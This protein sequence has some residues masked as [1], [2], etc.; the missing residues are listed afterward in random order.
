MRSGFHANDASFAGQLREEHSGWHFCSSWGERDLPLSHSVSS[1]AD[2]LCAAERGDEVSEVLQAPL[3]CHLYAS[4]IVSVS[5]LPS[6]ALRRLRKG[7]PIPPVKV[8]MDASQG[9]TKL[10][11]TIVLHLTASST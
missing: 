5:Q 4:G 1:G 6:H 10:G 2:K 8:V 9:P 3:L 11:V 7:P